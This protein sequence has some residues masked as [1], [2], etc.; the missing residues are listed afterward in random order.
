MVYCTC[1]TYGVMRLI[2]SEARNGLASLLS[3]YLL[4][5]VVCEGGLLRQ[6]HGSVAHVEYDGNTSIMECPRVVALR[7]LGSYT[8]PNRQETGIPIQRGAFVLSP[9]LMESNQLRLLTRLIMLQSPF[10]V[11]PCNS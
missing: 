1:K 11:R 8:P 6:P 2:R 10:P 3:Q 4:T 9:P 5:D 7:N